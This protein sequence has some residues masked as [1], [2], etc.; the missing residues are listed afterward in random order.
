MADYVEAKKKVR[1]MLHGMH[2]LALMTVCLLA[3]DL[4]ASQATWKVQLE[5]PQI[6]SQHIILVR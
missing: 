1:P 3:A 4:E 5:Q 6:P 2:G